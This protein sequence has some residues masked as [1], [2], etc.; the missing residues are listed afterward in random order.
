[1]SSQQ[2]EAAIQDEKGEVTAIRY[3]QEEASKDPKHV[4]AELYDQ[5]FRGCIRLW[6]AWWNLLFVD[7]RIPLYM[8]QAEPTPQQERDFLKDAEVVHIL[9]ILLGVLGDARLSDEEACTLSLDNLLALPKRGAV[10]KLINADCPTEMREHAASHLAAYS[11]L[12]LQATPRKD[13]RGGL[14]NQRI[15]DPL[16]QLGPDGLIPLATEAAVDFHRLQTTHGTPPKQRRTKHLLSIMSRLVQ[17]EDT[18]DYEELNEETAAVTQE[19]EIDIDWEEVSKRAKLSPLERRVLTL[20]LDN[21]TSH[22]YGD[23]TALARLLQTTPAAIGQAK[24]KIKHKVRSLGI[25]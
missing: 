24:Q 15:S 2:V 4:R 21:D 17:D 9:S 3:L 23:N 19:R 12:S 25:I 8:Q 20:L 14:A 10:L 13:G 11:W 18:S 16:S 5:W 22:G 7:L 1:M 6:T